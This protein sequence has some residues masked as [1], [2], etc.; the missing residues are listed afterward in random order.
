ME[1]V[2]QRCYEVC[3]LGDMQNLTGHGPGNLFKVVLPEQGDWT[4]QSSEVPSNLKEFL[5]VLQCAWH[6]RVPGLA[7]SFRVCVSSAFPWLPA[8]LNAPFRRQSCEHRLRGKGTSTRLSNPEHA[9]CIGKFLL[10]Q[11]SLSVDADTL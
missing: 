7:P 6:F 11:T 2:S 4:R 8:F 10:L 5:I 1:Q 3:F 9:S